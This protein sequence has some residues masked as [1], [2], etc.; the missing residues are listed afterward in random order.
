MVNQDL[1]ERTWCISIEVPNGIRLKGFDLQN[2]ARMLTAM[3]ALIRESSE[4][5]IG[6]RTLCCALDRRN[7]P[8]AV[9]A[10]QGA[11]RLREYCQEL[12]R[13]RCDIAVADKAQ[14]RLLLDDV[15][16]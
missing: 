5:E 15:K 14:L 1:S 10:A 8:A 3:G 4:L 2:D 7:I 16:E 9:A 13:S 11:A 6:L 12:L